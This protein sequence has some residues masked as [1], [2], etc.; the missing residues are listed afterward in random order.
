MK[1]DLYDVTS[2]IDQSAAVR[3]VAVIAYHC[4]PL[5]EPGAGD[6]GGMTVYVR[7]LA[8]ALAK[9]GVATDVFTRATSDL[10]RMVQVGEGV[11]VISIQAGPAE[12]LDKD[13]L[14]PYIDEF[15]AGISAFSTSQRARYDVVHSHY[16]QS[17]LA[18]MQLA[19]R[20]SVPLVHSNHTLG[21]VKNQWLAPGDAPEPPLRLN[22]ESKVIS[23][24]DVLVA[25]TDE[26]LAHLAC[27]YGANHDRMRT[28]HPGVDHELFSPGDG[29]AIRNELGI[30]SEA[31]VLL[32]VGRIQRLKGLDLA[33]QT[34]ARL[35]RSLDRP[36]FFVVIGGAS[37][38]AGDAEVA[39]LHQTAESLGIEKQ[40]VWLG[41][42]PHTSLPAF[43]RAADALLVCSHS[44]SFGLAALEAHSCG[45]PVIGTAVGGLSHVVEDGR[46]GWLIDQRDPAKFAARLEELLRDSS[47][48]NDFAAQAIA[49]SST[50][51]W[52]SAADQFLELYE[53]LVRAEFPEVCTC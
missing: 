24:A 18:G 11:R 3:R 46:S 30:S 19:P 35:R 20:W 48:K 29:V 4:S 43:Y 17:G 49:R 40:V 51:S 28:L 9:R 34:V 37:G 22:G 33:L 5:A 31:A 1:T 25:S 26:E 10:G 45:T 23:A 36:V 27:L 42:K 47:L 2:P 7:A 6:A 32:S 41:P 14:L 16:W 53:C 39:R 12:F 15:V 38:R 50:F 8:A 21:R 44:E 52:A 13:S